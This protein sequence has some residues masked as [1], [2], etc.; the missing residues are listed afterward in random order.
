[1]QIALIGYGKMGKAI[2]K[3]A[4]KNNHEI[5]VIIDNE[6]DWEQKKELLSKADVAIEF[7]TPAA[8]LQN[9]R[10]CFEMVLQHGMISL[11]K[12]RKNVRKKTQVCYMLPILALG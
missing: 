8:V 2:E 5:A 3:Q 4:L 12:L 6:D 1:M 10:H 9:L 11:K 7:S